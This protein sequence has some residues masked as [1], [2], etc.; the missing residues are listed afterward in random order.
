MEQLTGGYY[1]E[2]KNKVFAE[3]RWKETSATVVPRVIRRLRFAGQ[4]NFLNI[5]FMI[6]ER[7]K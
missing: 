1:S 3:I 6:R 5:Q 4:T 2:L 7:L